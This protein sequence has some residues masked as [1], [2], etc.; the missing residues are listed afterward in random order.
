MHGQDNDEASAKLQEETISD[1]KIY[2][3]SNIYLYDIPGSLDALGVYWQVH[4]LRKNG[5]GV[6]EHGLGKVCGEWTVLEDKGFGK[7]GSRFMFYNKRG[8]WVIAPREVMDAEADTNAD[9]NPGRVGYYGKEKDLVGWWRVASHALTPDKITET[10][11][12]MVPNLTMLGTTTLAHWKLNPSIKI[13][14][15]YND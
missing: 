5:R 11:Q 6:W 9:D 2:S 4:S 13:K 14:P 1:V 7:G 12:M 8:E 10:W 15:K 3:P